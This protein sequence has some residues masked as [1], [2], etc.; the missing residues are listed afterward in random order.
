[1]KKLFVSLIIVILLF[2]SFLTYSETLNITVNNKEYTLIISDNYKDLRNAF[3]NISK[4]YIDAEDNVTQLMGM[5]SDLKSIVADLTKKVDDAIVLLD[6]KVE[7]PF[8]QTMLLL[9]MSYDLQNQIIIGSIQFEGIIFDRLIIGI[10]AS[11]PISIGAE[12]G[13]KF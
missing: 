4:D 6:K 11:Y 7:V 2:V 8:W 10:Q 13:W 3:I 9:N 12:I 5:T 1:M